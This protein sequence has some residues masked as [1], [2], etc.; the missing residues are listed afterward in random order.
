M[1]GI[2]V[3]GTTVDIPAIKTL[4]QLKR[5]HVR[6]LLEKLRELQGKIKN[7]ETNGETS[8]FYCGNVRHKNKKIISD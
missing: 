1:G 4:Q 6:Y 7:Q 5:S 8:I 2:T 3:L